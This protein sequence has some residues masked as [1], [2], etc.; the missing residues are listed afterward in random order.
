MDFITNYLQKENATNEKCFNVAAA[1]VVLLLLEIKRYHKI[2]V[3]VA[4]SSA[5]VSLINWSVLV[6]LE[7]KMI[8]KEHQYKNRKENMP[9]L[10][11]IHCFLSWS[12]QKYVG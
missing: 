6:L 12:E 7:K 1:V 3:H 2:K 10:I 9:R 8:K 5:E 4:I 11:L